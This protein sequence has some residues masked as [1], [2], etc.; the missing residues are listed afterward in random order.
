M[1]VLL[2]LLLLLLLGTVPGDI[3]IGDNKCDTVSEDTP[4]SSVASPPEHVTS[5][6]P[7]CEG[8]QVEKGSRG[9]VGGEEGDKGR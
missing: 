3:D 5:F 6:L 7:G 2:L 8:R 4:T 1:H 9:R